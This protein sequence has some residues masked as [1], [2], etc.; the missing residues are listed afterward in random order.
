[1]ARFGQGFINSLTQPSYMQGMFTAAQQAGSMPARAREKKEESEF[2]SVINN[3]MLDGSS[4]S[5]A[6]AS[7]LA[8]SRGEREIAL[9]LAQASRQATQANK[10]ANV[11]SFEETGTNATLQAQKARAIQVARQRGDTQAL[12]ALT[13]GSISGS[14]YLKSVALAKKPEPKSPVSLT[15]NAVLV[16]QNT[17]EVIASNIQEEESEKPYS[18]DLGTAWGSKLLET[19]RTEEKAARNISVQLQSVL[20]QASELEETGA[21]SFVGGLLGK[22]RNFLVSDVAGLGDAITVHRSNLNSLRMQEALKL[23]PKGPA[24]DKDVALALDGTVNF[25]NLSPEQKVSYISG[26]KKLSDL[27]AKYS[28]AKISYITSTGDPNARGFE[29]YAGIIGNEATVD[30]IKL[31]NPTVVT[32][33]D[34]QLSRA[35]ELAAGGD[36]ESALAVIEA[37]RKIDE[38]QGLGYFKSLE[39]LEAS[40]QT[41]DSFVKDFNLNVKYL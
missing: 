38:E 18:D 28:E 41:F 16:D 1:M 14:D 22:A 33:L 15:K 2:T 29:Q 19:A 5:L 31:A 24:S 11:A 36:K 37:A 9:K 13:S 35:R 4:E 10:A 23:L 17:G 26:M 25:A 21:D 32:V 40:R 20:D 39:D 34:G 30:S 3:A 12:P 6:N 7:Q 8:A 27:E